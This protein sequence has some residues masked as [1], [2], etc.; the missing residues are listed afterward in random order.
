LAIADS[1]GKFLRRRNGFA[2]GPLKLSPI[3]RQQHNFPGDPE[4]ASASLRPC[5][6]MILAMQSSYTQ[7]SSYER[8]DRMKKSGPRLTFLWLHCKRS[9]NYAKSRLVG[10]YANEILRNC[11]AHPSIFKKLDSLSTGLSAESPAALLQ[12]LK[13]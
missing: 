9:C 7:A 3:D 1:L 12:P 8:A 4:Y 6:F 11:E 13:A 2:H 10:S 5:P